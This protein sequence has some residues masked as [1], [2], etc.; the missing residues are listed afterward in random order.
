ML[1]FGPAVEWY[2]ESATLLPH[3]LTILMG[4]SLGN[5]FQLPEFISAVVLLHFQ[6]VCLAQEQ[7]TARDIKGF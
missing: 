2:P 1:R 4:M 3:D 5:I 7:R 6:V